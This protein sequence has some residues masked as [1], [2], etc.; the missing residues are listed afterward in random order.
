VFGTNLFD[1]LQQNVDAANAFNRGMTNLSSMLAYAIVMAYDFAEISSLVDVGGGEGKLVQ[2]ILEVNPDMRGTV[3]DMPATVETGNEECNTYDGRCSYIAG[4]FFDWVPEGAGAYLLCGV[5]HD[6][7]DNRATKILTNCRRAT[8]G[9]GKLLLVEMVV[10]DSKSTSFS[11]FLDLN[12]LVM[13]GGRE[14]T[15]AEFCALLDVS[16]YKLT[17]IVPTLAPQSIIEAVPK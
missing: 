12:M 9:S 7:D 3:F 17:R 10:P 11:K 13:T 4:D 5:V 2:K 16:G 1:Y 15:K 6:W 14:R 8:A